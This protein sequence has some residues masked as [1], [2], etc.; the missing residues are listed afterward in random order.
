MALMRCT[1]AVTSLNPILSEQI[2]SEAISRRKAFCL[3][4]LGAAFSLA[5]PAVLTASDAEAQTAG[6]ERREEHRK[7]RHKRRE[8]RRKG[9]PERREKRHKPAAAPAQ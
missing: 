6:M 1:F 7:G 9:R 3:L 2:K 8:E 4:G 5:V